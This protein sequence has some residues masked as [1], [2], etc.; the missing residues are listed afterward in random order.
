[1]DPIYLAPVDGMGYPVQRVTDDP[2]SRPYASGLERL[3]QEIG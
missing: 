1:V 2:V 3:D